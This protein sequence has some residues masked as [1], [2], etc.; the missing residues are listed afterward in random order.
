MG[1][2]MSL[3]RRDFFRLAATGCAFCLAASRTTAAP[4]PGAAQGAPHWS[5]EGATGADHWG[6]LQPDFKVCSLVL[7]QTPIDLTGGMK[8][9]AESVA[10]DYRPLP[11]RILNNGHTIQVNADA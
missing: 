10:L 8:G 4:A 1:T 11:L 5:Y 9:E 2:H 6:E 7:E 3:R